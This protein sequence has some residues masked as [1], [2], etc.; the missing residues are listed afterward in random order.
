M[1]FLT[2]AIVIVFLLG[3]GF[4]VGGFRERAH[5][6]SLDRREAE[7]DDIGIANLKTVNDPQSV[8]YAGLVVA[9]CVIAT[10]YFKGFASA[11]RNILGGE[12]R[13]YQT[14]MERA[15]REAVLRLLERARQM[16]ANELW[17]LR[18]ETS[19]I[20][21]GVQQRSPAVAVEVTASATAVKRR[22]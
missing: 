19:N 6:K 10:D 16:G 2:E 15:R 8:E 18:L 5:F 12:M 17:N 4:L 7:Y 11:F 21:S 22:T 1:P 20:M 9:D 3:L 14:L 13:S